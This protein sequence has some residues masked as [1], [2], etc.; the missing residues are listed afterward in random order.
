MDFRAP[1]ALRGPALV[2]KPEMHQEASG[3]ESES[4]GYQWEGGRCLKM[5]D[6][7]E[8]SCLLAL[9]VCPSQIDTCEPSTA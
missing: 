9:H 2:F 7:A 5:A 1:A 3:T 4:L 6:V 8:M